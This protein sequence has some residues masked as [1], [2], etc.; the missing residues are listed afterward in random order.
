M[1]R[2]IS[3]EPETGLSNLPLSIFNLISYADEIGATDLVLLQML[4]VYL[5]EHRPQILDVIDT[6][7]RS[8]AAIME[9][10]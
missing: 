4:T 7:K 3:F 6:K 2:H 1:F 5:K 10:L 8:I 9:I